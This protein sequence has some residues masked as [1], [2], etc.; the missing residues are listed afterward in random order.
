MGKACVS[1]ME[2]ANHV[3][4]AAGSYLGAEPQGAS[5]YDDH[6]PHGGVSSNPNEPQEETHGM[7]QYQWGD[8]MGLVDKCV[9]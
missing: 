6:G 4:R 2:I 1:P 9:D 5:S 8:I 7:R 3:D